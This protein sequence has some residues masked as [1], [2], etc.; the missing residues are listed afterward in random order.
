VQLLPNL[1]LPVAAAVK[2]AEYQAEIDGLATFA[3]R[4]EAGKR[5]FNSRNNKSNVT[6]NAIKSVLTNMCSGA[7]RCVY[8]ED[9]AAD[10]VEHIY[11]KHF[12]PDRVFVWENFVYACGPCNGPKASSFAVFIVNAEAKV[13]LTRSA[14]PSPPPI[15]VPGLI[16]PRLEDATQ[17]LALDLRETFYFVERATSGTLEHQRASYTIEILGLN[18][19]E[20][21]RLARRAAY[22]DYRAHLAQY[23]AVRT[24]GNEAEMQ[25]LAHEIR[26]RQHPTVWTE[27]KRQHANLPDLAQLFADSPEALTW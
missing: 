10:E 24:S 17:L 11:P 3:E 13:E 16:D 2:L 12:Y 7:R 19:R 1:P 20:Y 21:L 26:T 22:R 4:V 25:R 5:L 18:K 8:C 23:R 9:S 14:D 27:M 15:G 6:F